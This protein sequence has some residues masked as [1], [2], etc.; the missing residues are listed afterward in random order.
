MPAKQEMY[1]IG[2]GAGRTERKD[3]PKP[4]QAACSIL[5][6]LS[7]EIGWSPALGQYLVLW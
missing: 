4:V 7:D 1:Y 3:A 5:P 2:A 6:L